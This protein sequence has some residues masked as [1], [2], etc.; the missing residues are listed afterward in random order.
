MNKIPPTPP[1]HFSLYFFASVR[2]AYRIWNNGRILIFKVSKW[3]YWSHLHDRIIYKWCQYLLGGQ[4][5]NYKNYSITINKIITNGQILVFEVS[6]WPY[7]SALHNRTICKWHQCLLGG[8]KWNYKNHSTTINKIITCGQR[9]LKSKSFIKHTPQK[10]EF[11]FKIQFWNFQK[12][13]IK[14]KKDPLKFQKLKN[15]YQE[16]S[17]QN[18]FAKFLATRA[19]V[20][21]LAN[22]PIMSARSVRHPVHYFRI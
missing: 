16:A 5:W 18:F 3:L 20:A 8:Q 22:D 10:W 2:N 19:E 11:W 1:T 12:P 13:K 17:N 14:L 15:I 6:I 7:Q 9:I 21:S 4:K